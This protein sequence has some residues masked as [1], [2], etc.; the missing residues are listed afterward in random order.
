[1]KSILL[2]SK[3]NYQGESYGVRV[4]EKGVFYLYVD[5][6]QKLQADSFQSLRSALHHELHCSR[7]K[8][9]VPL[10]IVENVPHHVR[11]ARRVTITGRHYS[12][13]NYLTKDGKRNG[14]LQRFLPSGTHY[15]TDMSDEELE[16]L[17]ALLRQLDSAE[18][19][20]RAILARLNY[21]QVK[22]REDVNQAL[23]N[24]RKKPPKTKKGT[25]RVATRRSDAKSS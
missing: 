24:A 15:L 23:L 20:V 14:Q 17:W 2:K 5:A 16:D 11:T 7:E 4:D 21:S 10:I 1:M 13:N 9:A 18:S 6:S 12:N 8:I 22:I 25:K 19:A 3:I